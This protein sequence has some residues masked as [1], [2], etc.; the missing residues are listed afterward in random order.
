L[1]K[2]AR[3]FRVHIDQLLRLS[4]ARR[5]LARVGGRPR[6][7]LGDGVDRER[8]ILAAGHA[9]RS[10]RHAGKRDPGDLRTLRQQLADHIDGHVSVHDI[11]ADE[12]R[13]A[14]L[15]FLRD[16]RLL[17][18]LGEIVGRLD[19]DLKPGPFTGRRYSISKSKGHAES[20]AGS[21]QDGNHGSAN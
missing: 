2:L 11:A 20:N 14:A 6:A 19:V 4:P 21:P 10:A 1:A 9:R 5:S 17:A 18:D 7:V 13:M 12:P 16:A 8:P 3:G 15:E